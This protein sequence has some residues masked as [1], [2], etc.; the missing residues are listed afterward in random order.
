MKNEIKGI[1]LANGV[2]IGDS[3]QYYID[4]HYGFDNNWRAKFDNYV[5]NIFSDKS[6]KILHYGK[7]RLKARFNKRQDK[8]YVY[9]E[10]EKISVCDFLSEGYYSNNE[11]VQC[12]LNN[13]DKVKAF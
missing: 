1:R 13:L 10:G 12:F 2:S 9:M 7:H 6:F 3:K 11:V 5:I 8:A 4:V